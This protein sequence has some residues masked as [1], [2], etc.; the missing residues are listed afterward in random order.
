MIVTRSNGE[1]VELRV[2]SVDRLGRRVIIDIPE[3]NGRFTFSDVTDR[4]VLVDNGRQSIVKTKPAT[5]HVSQSVYTGMAKWAGSILS[6][7]R[8]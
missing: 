4:V 8:R 6:D 5:V 2:V 3:Y 7:R 1:L